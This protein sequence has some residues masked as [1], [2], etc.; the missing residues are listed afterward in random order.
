MNEVPR[1]FLECFLQS[2]MGKVDKG[3]STNVNLN[4]EMEQKDKY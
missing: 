1:L 2:S 4:Y 3:F